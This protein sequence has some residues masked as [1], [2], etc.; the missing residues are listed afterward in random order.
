MSVHLIWGPMTSGMYSPSID[1]KL[2][3]SLRLSPNLSRTYIEG[4]VCLTGFC[5]LNMAREAS[6]ANQYARILVSSGG[7]H[8]ALGN[9]TPHSSSRKVVISVALFR[10]AASCAIV[11]GAATLK[12][13]EHARKFIT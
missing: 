3:G 12:T 2:V 9:K 7:T 11:S 5:L 4:M 10:D 1:V 13:N 6:L 8:S